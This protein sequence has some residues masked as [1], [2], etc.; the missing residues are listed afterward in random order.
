MKIWLRGSASEGDVQSC[1]EQ[2][3]VNCLLGVS[4]RTGRCRAP[5]VH[6]GQHAGVS[7][8]PGDTPLA[9]VAFPVFWREE[10][11]TMRVLHERCCGLDIHKKFVVACFLATGSDGT[12]SKEVRT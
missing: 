5:C 9:S 6:R 7:V 12:V 1:Q 11:C 8:R 4:R 3:P 2:E 10:R